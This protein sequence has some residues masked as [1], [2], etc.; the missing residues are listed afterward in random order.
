MPAPMATMSSTRS[1]CTAAWFTHTGRAPCD[2]AVRLDLVVRGRSVAAVDD[3]DG[4]AV[5]VVHVHKG[6]IGE[7]MRGGHRDVVDGH[8]GERHRRDPFGLADWRPDDADGERS[9]AE[10]VEDRERREPVGAHGDV[11]LLG[12]QSPDRPHHAALAAVAV[13]DAER[14]GGGGRQL[15]TDGA[16]AI[17][18]PQHVARLDE[19]PLAGRRE[20]H[21]AARALEEAD[22]EVLLELADALRQR[23][24]RH[25][26]AGGRPT[27][28]AFLGDR[29]EVAQVPHVGLT[30]SSR[31]LSLWT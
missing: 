13:T 2:C 10:L 22:P 30:A 31:T 12:Q 1:T 16:E 3:E 8:A 5:E 24:R 17:H 7:T 19:Q 27:E 21:L 4:L 15:G 29:H 14:N 20:R 11:G 26:Q 9:G 28:V 25:V 23:W 6:D 18:R